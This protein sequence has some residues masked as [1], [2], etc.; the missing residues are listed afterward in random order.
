MLPNLDLSVI[1]TGL[2][3]KYQK[4]ELHVLQFFAAC[5]KKAIEI[6]QA[7]SPWV[8]QL[9]VF[10]ADSVLLMGD[11]THKALHLQFPED[12]V[13][14]PFAALRQETR[15]FAQKWVLDPVFIKNLG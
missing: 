1:F 3:Q 9:P 7:G 4:D 13:D 2:A 11:W 14:D 12:F 8:E 6:S 10:I 5:Q 15:A